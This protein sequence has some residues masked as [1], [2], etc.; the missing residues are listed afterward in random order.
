MNKLAE[1]ASVYCESLYDDEEMRVL[2]LK[3]IPTNTLNDLITQK[4]FAT[5]LLQISPSPWSAG[6]GCLC[7]CC[8]WLQRGSERSNKIPFGSCCRCRDLLYFEG[9]ADQLRALLALPRDLPIASKAT[10]NP[11]CRESRVGSD[12][13]TT[14]EVRVIERFVPSKV[15]V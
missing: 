7:C 4:L 2:S 12:D 8:Y 13:A 3:Q 9:K 1:S 11:F 10:K 15:K 6:C 14:R 5:H